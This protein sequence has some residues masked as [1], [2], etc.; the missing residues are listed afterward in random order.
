MLLRTCSF[1]AS[2]VIF[3]IGSSWTMERVLPSAQ[4]KSKSLQSKIN[5]LTLERIKPFPASFDHV[6]QYVYANCTQVT[7]LQWSAELFKRLKAAVPSMTK[8]KILKKIEEDNQRAKKSPPSYEIEE[9]LTNKI[10]CYD[11]IHGMNL[12]ENLLRE[13]KKID[14]ATLQKI[15]AAL[16]RMTELSEGQE[17]PGDFRKMQTWWKKKEMTVP[18][19]VLFYA[20]N[21]DRTMLLEQNHPFLHYDSKNDTCDFE[22]I[23]NLLEY[24]EQISDR[25]PPQY[26][27]MPVEQA[28]TALDRWKQEQASDGQVLKIQPW[29]NNRMHFFPTFEGIEKQLEEAL[30]NFEKFDHPVARA[31]YLMYEVVRIHPWHEANKRTGRAVA[32][33]YLLGHGY[34]PP[35]ITKEHAKDFKP[36]FIDNFDKEDGFKEFIKFFA[37]RVEETQNR[38]KEAN[39]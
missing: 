29:L 28:A 30:L 18:E 16:T 13:K 20:L 11:W 2:I 33:L 32:A 3:S 26:K 37:Q 36:V 24:A 31:A 5:D 21:A 7:Y 38:F 15:N 14:R 10:E 25:L 34:L 22:G 27:N 39:L 4:E 6:P 8:E 1:L 19:E 35:L 12:I 9:E 17:K 23:K